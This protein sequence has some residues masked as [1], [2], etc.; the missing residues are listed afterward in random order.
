VCAGINVL[1]MTDV[2]RFLEFLPSKSETDILMRLNHGI[3]EYVAVYVDDLL[4][5]AHDTSS[6]TNAL[7][8]QHHF[9]LKGRDLSY[10]TLVVITLRTTLVPYVL[11]PKST[12]R[13]AV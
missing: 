5:D 11:V 1:P 3:Y 10:T 2:L 9:K 7:T 4:I 8:N 12:S 13:R 6:I